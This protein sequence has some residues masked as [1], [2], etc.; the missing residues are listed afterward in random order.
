MKKKLFLFTVD[1]PFGFGE[2]FL[3]NELP[4][5]EKEFDVI[6]IPVSCYGE[7]TR[8]TNKSIIDTGCAEYLNLGCVA[9]AHLTALRKPAG[10]LSVKG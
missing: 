1:F 7:K 10:R 2:G 4:F 5:L 6:I 8:L 3:E 9:A